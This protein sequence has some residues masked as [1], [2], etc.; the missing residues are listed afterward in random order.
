MIRNLH[1][2]II[3]VLAFVQFFWSCQKPKSEA[4]IAEQ[5]CKEIQMVKITGAKELYYLG[6][7]IHLDVNL[8]PTISL[9]N[10]SVGDNP[11]T[12]SGD[13]YIYIPSCTKNNEGWYYLSVSY[14]DCSSHFD[15]VYIK[16]I[17]KPATVVPPDTIRA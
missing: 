17:N 6:D 8:I 3:S 9:F 12:I 13:P 2:K 4:E 1:L 15:S 14:P 10:W 5:N 11:T 7:S 16:V